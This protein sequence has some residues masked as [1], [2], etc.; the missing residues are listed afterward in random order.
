MIALALVVL[1]QDS[2]PATWLDQV[3]WK[4]DRAEATAEAAGARKPIASVTEAL[5]F[6]TTVE[7][8]SH[9]LVVDALETECVPIALEKHGAY[10]GAKLCFSR[11]DGEQLGPCEPFPR[12]PHDLGAAIATALRA[13]GRDVPRY[14]A[15]AIEETDPATIASR[16]ASAPAALEHLDASPL[17][18]VSL[19]PLQARRVDVSLARGEN[20]SVWLSYRQTK[21]AIAVAS[22]LARNPHAFDGLRRPDSVDGFPAYERELASRLR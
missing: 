12:T 17:R 3:R 5:A 18:F 15:V 4:H 8:L 14:L 10:H 16:P 21:M 22:I 2:R 19:T 7:A 9:P 13:C 11:A 1:A 6:G 20:A